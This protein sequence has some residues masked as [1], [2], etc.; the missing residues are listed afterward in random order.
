MVVFIKV[1]ASIW[2]RGN[3]TLLLIKSKNYEDLQSIEPSLGIRNRFKIQKKTLDKRAY[4]FNDFDEMKKAIN[5]T[6]D[7]NSLY[8]IKLDD[9]FLRNYSFHNNKIDLLNNVFD[10]LTK[11]MNKNTTRE[12][13]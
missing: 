2:I 10:A 13:L 1:V 6:I 11:L 7:N 5:S 9:S 3:K 12:F 4:I 8:P